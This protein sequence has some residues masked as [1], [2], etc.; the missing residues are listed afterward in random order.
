MKFHPHANR[1]LATAL[2]FV[3]ALAACGGGSEEAVDPIPTELAGVES[4][5]ESGFDAA[6]KPD[7]A[8][9]ATAAQQAGRLGPLCPARGGRRRTGRRARRGASG[10]R[11]LEQPRRF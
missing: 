1:T 10:A 11:R 6:L 8:Q 9:V 4:A 3:F 2:A 7:Q 5:A